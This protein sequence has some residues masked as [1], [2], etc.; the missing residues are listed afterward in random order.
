MLL[1]E[2]LQRSD[3]EA[4]AVV[5]LTEARLKL[6]SQETHSH[7]QDVCFLQLGV[8]LML[9]ELLLQDGL[10]LLDAS[11]DAISAHFLHNRFS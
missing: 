6:L 2:A 3:G 8:G 1:L 9:L 10:E 7:L 11:V 4:L 5:A